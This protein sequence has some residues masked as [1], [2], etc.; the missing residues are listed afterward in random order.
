MSERLIKQSIA[1]RKKIHKKVTLSQFLFL[2]R[3][4]EAKLLTQHELV[5]GIIKKLNEAE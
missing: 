5:E 2:R 1:K 4:T 3:L